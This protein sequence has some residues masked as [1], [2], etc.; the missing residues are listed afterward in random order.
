M[1][2]KVDLKSSDIKDALAGYISNK[3]FPCEVT[4]W[5]MSRKKGEEKSVSVVCSPSPVQENPLEDTE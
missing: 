3:Y 5:T 1:E 4:D 2:L